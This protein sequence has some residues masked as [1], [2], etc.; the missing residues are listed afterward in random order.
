[1]RVISEG[2]DYAESSFYTNRRDSHAGNTMATQAYNNSRFAFDYLTR[3]FTSLS[4][5]PL[6]GSS[7]LNEAASL[8][9]EGP[10]QWLTHDPNR[11]G[12]T[13]FEGRATLTYPDTIGDAASLRT[14]N[15]PRR[16]DYSHY[17]SGWGTQNT[18]WVRH[19]DADA[20]YERA[21]FTV[22]AS[23]YPYGTTTTRGYG[24]FDITG[25]S[26]AD[27]SG[28]PGNSIGKFDNTNYRKHKV[29]MNSS[30]CGVYLGETGESPAQSSGM[31][32]PYSYLYP[33]KSPSGKPFFRNTT[34]RRVADWIDVIYNDD[35][36][37]KGYFRFNTGSNFGNVGGLGADDQWFPLNTVAANVAA[38]GQTYNAGATSIVIPSALLTADDKTNILDPTN[39]RHLPT[40]T[41]GTPTQI[42]VVGS[43][44][45][46]YSAFSINGSGDLTFTLTSGLSAQQ[47]NPAIGYFKWQDQASGDDTITFY[48][49]TAGGTPD[50]AP[51][52]QNRQDTSDGMAYPLLSFKNASGTLRTTTARTVMGGA[53]QNSPSWNVQS[54][55]SKGYT[56]HLV[57]ATL[58][59]GHGGFQADPEYSAARDPFFTLGNVYGRLEVGDYLTRYGS[60]TPEK[61]LTILSDG[62]MKTD[63][64]F[65]GPGGTTF[66]RMAT[67]GSG[68]GGTTGRSKDGMFGYQPVIVGDTEL[69]AQTD[70]ERFTIRLANQSFNQTASAIPGQVDCSFML[71]VGYNKSEAGFSMNER[72]N[73]LGTKAAITHLFRPISGLGLAGARATQFNMFVEGTTGKQ[74]HTMDQLWY[75]LD[76][77]VDFTAQGYYVFNDGT[78]VGALTPFNAKTGGG[79]WT[80]DD[81]YGW[82]LG[83][84]FPQGKD[85]SDTVGWETMTTMIDRAGY[86]YAI[87]D[88]MTHASIPA[89]IQQDDVIFDKFKI[90]SMVDGIAQAE[91]TLA[92]DNDLLN[93]PQLVSG[94]PNWKMLLFRDN[95]YRPIHSS[96]VSA[97]NFK[98]NAKKKSKE[99]ILKSQD[100]LGELD[101]QFP[102]FDIGQENGAPSLVAHYR[103]YEVTNYAEIFHFGTT[104]LLNLNPFL[105]FDEDSK[106]STGEYLPRYDQRMRL[107]SGHPIQLY[108]NE[109]T[110]GPNYTE[111]AWEVSR[112]IDH[113]RPHPLDATKTKVV[114]KS[115]H[116]KYAGDPIPAGVQ[117]A[118]KGNWRNVGAVTG[119]ITSEKS[120]P[121]V[122]E[123]GLIAACNGGVQEN[124]PHNEYRGLWT[125]EQAE[126]VTTANLIASYSFLTVADTSLFP[127]SGTVKVGGTGT[128]GNNGTTYTYSSKTATRLNLTT[129]LGQAWG[130]GTVV[131][132]TTASDHITIDKVWKKSLRL[133][134]IR[135]DG[136]N[137]VMDFRPETDYHK[138][139]E[140]MGG[141]GFA[142]AQSV[143]AKNDRMTPTLSPNAELIRIYVEPNADGISQES[144]LADLPSQVYT[145]SEIL[146][147]GGQSSPTP[148]QATIKTS[149]LVSDLSANLQAA[150]PIN[151]NNNTTGIGDAIECDLA[152]LSFPKE[153]GQAFTL[154]NVGS[155][156]S[157]RN[158]QTRWMRDLPQSLWFQK[159]YGVIGQYPYG[160]TAW[161]GTTLLNAALTTLAAEFNTAA[162]NTIT[163]GDVTNFPYSGVCEIWT[164]N[165][166]PNVLN[167]RQ[168]I[169]LTS[170]TYVGKDSA[171]NRLTNVKFADPNKGVIATS[172][173]AGNRVV[174][175]RNID[176]DY[177][178]CF[179]LFADMR[180]DGS[181][182]ADGGT[183]KSDFGLL[184][185]IEQNY[186][187][188]VVWAETGKNFV[189]LKIGA[190][191]DIWQINAQNDPA[192]GTAWSD[193]PTA[194][195]LDYDNPAILIG[196]RSDDTELLTQY[197]NWEDKAGAFV[198]VDLS[199]FFNL[200]TEANLGRIGQ[201]AGGNKQLGEFLVEGA[202]EPTLIDN[203]HYQAAATYQNSVAPLLQ[204]FNSYRWADAETT[205]T[206]DIVSAT[207]TSITTAITDPTD[208]EITV[209][210]N[211]SFP[212]SGTNFLL[213]ADT[214]DYT[215]KGGILASARPA[216]LGNDVTGNGTF[217]TSGG[218]ATTNATGTYLAAFPIINV[219][220]D[221]AGVSPTGWGT[222]KRYDWE[223]NPAGARGTVDSD[224]NGILD[225]TTGSSFV[226]TSDSGFAAGVVPTINILKRPSGAK[227][228][229]D[230][231]QNFIMNTAGKLK[232]NQQ[233]VITNPGSGFTSAPTFTFS[234]SSTATGRAT[235][236]TTQ[237][238]GITGVAAPA[239]AGTGIST[240]S[241]IDY[242]D[243]ES[244]DNFPARL[245]VNAFAGENTAGIIEAKTKDANGNEYEM[246]YVFTYTS[247]TLTRLSG[248]QYRPVKQGETVDTAAAGLWSGDTFTVQ[249]VPSINAEGSS[250]RASLGSSF[251]MGFMLKL[252]GKVK[253]PGIGNFY[254][255]DKIRVFQQSALF[256]DWFKQ[257]TLPALSDFNNVPIM[258]DF[259]VDG[260]VAGAGAV[261]S[262]G[263][264]TQ[265]QNKSVFQ[266]LRTMAQAAGV[267]DSG[268]LIT[269]NFQMGR[270]N[271]MEFR[272]TYNS[273]L[274]LDR[275][276][277]KVSDL[278]TSK[279][280]SFSHIRVLYN[281]GDSFVTFPALNYKDNVRFKFVSAISVTS[282]SQAIE[283]A[284]QEYQKKKE[285]AFKVEAEVV[286]QSN[287]TQRVGPMLENARY[288]YIAD[289]AIQ[290]MGRNGGYW[291]AG[292]GGLH[293]TGQNNA[294]HGNTHGYGLLSLL[295]YQSSAVIGIGIGGYAGANNYTTTYGDSLA[296]YPTN[297][298]YNMFPWTQMYYWYGARSVSYAVQIVHIPKAMP[299]VSETTGEELRIFISDAVATVPNA[300]REFNTTAGKK[301]SIH[302]ADYNFDESQVLGHVPKLQATQHGIETITTLGSGYF[303]VPIPESYWAAGNA[304]GYKMVVS[305]NAEYLAAVARHKTAD[306]FGGNAAA[307]QTGVI[308]AGGQTAPVF[309]NV[310]E[311]SIFPLGIREY[312]ELGSS[313]VERAPYY[314][315]RIHITDDINFI[316]GTYAQYN[317][318]Y[319][320]INE[321]L[322]ISRVEY[323][324]TNKKSDRTKLVLEREVGRIPEGLEGYLATN[325]L[326]DTGASG[327]GVGGGGGGQNTPPVSPGGA[328]GRGD[329]PTAPY[330]PPTN[331]NFP[332]GYTGGQTG[333]QFSNTSPPLVGGVSAD[334]GLTQ[335]PLLSGTEYLRLNND[336][337]VQQMG[338]EGSSIAPSFSANNMDETTMNKSNGT[339]SIDTLL[340]NGVQ[341]IPGQP[342]PTR[343]PQKTR[344][345]E[346]IDTK[347]VSAEGEA[348]ETDGGWILPGASTVGLSEAI[349]KVQHSL[350]LSGTIPMDSAQPVIGLTAFVS[351]EILDGD[352]KF[353]LETT[354][355]C[356][357]TGESLTHTHTESLE[358]SAGITVNRKQITLIPQ[359]F[360]A[361]AGVEGRRLKATIT[362]KPGQGVDDMNFSSVVIHGVQFENVVHNNQGTPTS[363]NLAAFAGTVKDSTSDNLNLNSDTNPL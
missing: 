61:I 264:V 44:V 256:D 37:G 294:L 243:V 253:T 19:G 213:G 164:N 246:K 51:V 320:D 301:F 275:N 347:F 124:N 311:F 262:F 59:S 120:P 248:I 241:T 18:Y 184:H 82:S 214:F 299:K 133:Q 24:K 305:V 362:R 140:F 28:I 160:A 145:S 23:G 81:F 226:I 55:A 34:S 308:L 11:I 261:E 283:I 259:N 74:T 337:G 349:T 176:G 244:T 247:K 91:F 227:D 148:I 152:Y 270:D 155:S 171:N 110:N 166:N 215:A 40:K 73:A 154:R 161:R 177:K 172:G 326:E 17:A 178:H 338:Q 156:Y 286:R 361:S 98:Q 175:A 269:L 199:K 157:Y 307:G 115:D 229:I 193:N 107:Y 295:N 6:I 27:T 29:M 277:L 233:F 179:V 16:A 26:P 330:I 103:R 302:F 194:I 113:F 354:L 150:L 71:S 300:D 10:S 192:T 112:L 249:G 66:A 219:K 128:T 266:T 203:Y 331:D 284:K 4:P 129:T 149:I 42:V 346:G 257:M 263:G 54:N 121:S 131:R 185:P 65:V 197:H 159:T 100:S 260:N 119:S 83:V 162:D 276:N 289:P 198:I 52:F 209:Q 236:S 353:T 87:S 123:K 267:G 340:P 265:A 78:L 63:G 30:L 319:L 76:I 200:N 15:Y 327:G 108:S 126:T 208:T 218:G 79:A 170:F 332:F 309:S 341:G 225:L 181:A 132:E 167:N 355:T 116:I 329:G 255:H 196:G 143:F 239:P 7:A 153:R 9:N 106:G 43:E 250:I 182:D 90:K 3:S 321:T 147:N 224:S 271:R 292:R 242:L 94:R 118:I 45:K 288:G 50:V 252:E 322:F 314:A 14:F 57:A 117:V 93:L 53:G 297:D 210:D 202:G 33:I 352:E 222:S 31:S 268:S 104:S 72:G 358:P 251:P 25:T 279:A 127:T 56:Y 36:A 240:A 135:S 89:N 138:E 207:P 84:H 96:I 174:L 281:G 21:S 234:T 272:P 357:D 136:T 95:D 328:G 333:T 201:T 151:A 125:V 323:E 317:D 70:G 102:Y 22:A 62:S 217:T 245:G 8:H 180:N 169:M 97:V 318:A 165:P 77:V 237:L 336:T 139:Y 38:T 188:K 238:C 221:P 99:I 334:L 313:A 306:K 67:Y 48:N 280:K 315:P 183:R 47:A 1:M 134:N 2:E 163:L 351:A 58:K 363:E 220:V 287:E 216:N 32:L 324:Y 325:P 228:G 360:F 230:P 345:M 105:G 232:F 312:P 49:L 339:M 278:K 168:A 335:T 69:N 41:T 343:I 195:M 5:I 350:T 204:H 68:N 101:F 206:N 86:I 75:D 141:T 359:Q 303:E 114:L 293:F 291:T 146:V 137:L 144:A 80:A 60:D 85:T 130:P 173:G 12:A 158:I 88:R 13:F 109:N 20:T 39:D 35:G 296:H 310:N 304:A 205:L 223:T 190:D 282:Y 298:L 254:E 231:A 290:L 46:T 187:L 344:A 356:E 122:G 235:L 258:E 316:A 274:S 211:A 189:D 111:D 342:R 273:G 142:N 285:P 64:A 92:D 212:S 186:K 191:A 348:A